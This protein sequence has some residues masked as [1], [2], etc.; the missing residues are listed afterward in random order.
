MSNITGMWNWEGRAAG[1]RTWGV[2]SRYFPPNLGFLTT[3]SAPPPHGP[4]LPSAIC[5]PRNLVYVPMTQTCPQSH[6]PNLCHLPPLPRADQM[7]KLKYCVRGEQRMLGG[8]SG[9]GKG[10]T[11]PRRLLQDPSDSRG[12]E[13]PTVKSRIRLAI[14]TLCWQLLWQTQVP[15]LWRAE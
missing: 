10:Q 12:P 1:G 11:D 5:R 7:R 3:W 2:K 15:S 6:H 4:A 14:R 9:L 13:G 8:C